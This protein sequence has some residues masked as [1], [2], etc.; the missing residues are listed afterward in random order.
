VCYNA[1]YSRIIGVIVE[2]EI[3]YKLHEKEISI[4]SRII[5]Y[6]IEEINLVVEA[7]YCGKYRPASNYEPEEYPELEIESSVV[8]SL[9]AVGMESV[10]E[11]EKWLSDI[12]VDNLDW[13]YLNEFIEDRLVANQESSRMEYYIERQMYY[14][15]K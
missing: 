15:D 2:I 10:A 1:D 13:S 9:N 3:Y 5:G 12:I 6:D 11:V 7:S 14:N 8:E 4:I